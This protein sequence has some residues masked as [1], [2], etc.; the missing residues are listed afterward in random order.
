MSEEENAT[1]AT[2]PAEES[3]ADKPETIADGEEAAAGGPAEQA[4]GEAHTQQNEDKP[5]AE[6]QCIKIPYRHSGFFS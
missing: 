3:G 5:V 1:G 2:A 6:G 4:N